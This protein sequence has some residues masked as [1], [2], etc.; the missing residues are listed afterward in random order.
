MN[1]LLTQSCYFDANSG[2]IVFKC[3][4]SVSEM[5][6]FIRVN[7]TLCNIQSVAFALMKCGVRNDIQSF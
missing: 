5:P 1:N 2:F 6:H 4:T 3:H 7:A